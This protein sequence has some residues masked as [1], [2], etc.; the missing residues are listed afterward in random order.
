[1][2]AVKGNDRA[3][4]FFVVCASSR[5]LT[6]AGSTR[7]ASLHVVDERG[8]AGIDRG[9]IEVI[10]STV[11][12]FREA[13]TRENHTLKRALTD[14]TLFSGI[15]NAYSD[16]ILHRARLSPLKLTAKMTMEE[17]AW[18]HAATLTLWVDRLREQ[19]GDGFPVKVTAFRPDM[20]VHGRFGSPVPAC[21]APV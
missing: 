10:G 3:S 6:E 16:E 17:I 20:A 13:L 4:P 5:M 8:V 1:M 14:P 2:S 11:D 12:A 15:G 19:T 18:L 21:G 7:R 9:G